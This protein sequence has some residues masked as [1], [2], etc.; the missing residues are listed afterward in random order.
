M[1]Q[2]H[3]V[4]ARRRQHNT[5]TMQRMKVQGQISYALHHEC[6]DGMNPAMN[7]EQQQNMDVMLELIGTLAIMIMTNIQSS[8]T[9]S[10][11]A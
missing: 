9:K 5:H 1:E 4:R 11:E 7:T 2:T 3:A 6:S 8:K 10:T